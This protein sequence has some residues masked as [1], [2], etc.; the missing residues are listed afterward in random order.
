MAKQ[1]ADTKG[2]RGFVL[3]GEGIRILVLMSWV[4]AVYFVISVDSCPRKLDFEVT[5]VCTG[6]YHVEPSS[7]VKYTPNFNIL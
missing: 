2:G 3:R 5:S 4:P 1:I 7:V 6:Q